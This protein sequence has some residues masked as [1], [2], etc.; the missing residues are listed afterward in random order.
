MDI[1]VM[2]STVL[3][4]FMIRNPFYLADNTNLIYY[5]VTNGNGN[6]GIENGP[7]QNHQILSQDKDTTHISIIINIFQRTGGFR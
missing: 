3:I 7:I 2:P 1:Q 6:L 4:T 5:G